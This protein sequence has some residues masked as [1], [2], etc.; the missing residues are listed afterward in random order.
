MDG[1]IRLYALELETGKV[2]H[3]GTVSSAG[4][5]GADTI[6]DRAL[7][8]ILSAEKGAV[9]MRGLGVD[10]GLS[11]VEDQPHLFAPRGFLDDTWW[12]RTYWIYG[13]KIA[14]GYTHWPDVGNQS[15]A[16]R[17]LAFDGGKLIYGYGRMA[18][19]MGDGHVRPDMA[20][21]Y[22]L[23]AEIRELAPAAARRR[24]DK[25]RIQWTAQLPFVAR[26]VVLTRD[27]LLVAGGKSP[28]E[29]AENHGPGTFWV[30]SRED[31]SKRAA[32][33][34]PAPPV[35]DGMALTDAGVLVST[36]DGTIVCLRTENDD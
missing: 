18:Y 26:S 8:D 11:P 3:A 35:L 5:G 22:K 6:R 4:R 16:G 25:R 19:R 10:K 17:L 34:L 27:A 20:K 2:L 21:D 24:D 32:C 23:F 13:T 1:G 31:G 9:W 14:G 7:P 28:T 30:A 36:I 33:A 12:H 15:P 29:T